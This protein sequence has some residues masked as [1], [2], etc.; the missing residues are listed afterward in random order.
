MAGA[1][2]A[3]SDDPL[4]SEIARWQTFLATHQSSGEIWKQV[5]ESTRSNLADASEALANGR[6]AL[7]LQKLV[8]VRVNLSAMEYLDT[9]PPSELDAAGFQAEWKRMGEVLHGELATPK[10]DAFAGIRPAVARA[11]A[12]AASLQIRAFYDAGLDYGLNT[13]TQSGLYFAGGAQAQ[14]DFVALAGTFL[15]PSPKPLP[16]LA[17]LAP[18]LDAFEDALLAA[19]VPPASI[20]RHPDF[21]AASAALKEARELDAAGLRDGALY[22]YLQAAQRLPVV[23]NGADVPGRLAALEKRL[24]ESPVD[25]SIGQLYLEI[26][27]ADLAAAAPDR[28]ATAAAAI[29]DDVL[30]RY[31][32]ALA[33]GPRPSPTPRPPAEVTVTLVRWPYT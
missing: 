28:P 33:V 16:R 6:R 24:D 15:P 8:S 12:E 19:Y 20:D 3:P 26:A 5:Q 2:G 27:R 25:S 7:A 13:M 1:G 29:A 30:P 31:F 9:R 11:F 23:R 18:Q 32:A 17:P 14:R 22:K 10:P 4:A 21:I